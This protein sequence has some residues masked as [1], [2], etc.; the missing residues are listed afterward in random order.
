MSRADAFTQ[1][2]VDEVGACRVFGI[3]REPL[4]QHVAGGFGAA[5]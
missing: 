1:P 3:D 2:L 4:A 5:A